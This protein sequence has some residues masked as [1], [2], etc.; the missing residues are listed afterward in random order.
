MECARKVT[1][2]EDTRVWWVQYFGKQPDG[3]EGGYTGWHQDWTSWSAEANSA[4]GAPNG[5]AVHLLG[6]ARGR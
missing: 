3:V 1:G 6:G 5:W 4:E 2:L